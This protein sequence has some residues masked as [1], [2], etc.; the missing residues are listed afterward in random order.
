MKHTVSDEAV[1]LLHG[2]ARSHRSLFKLEKS[3]NRHGYQTC[4]MNYASTRF[5]IEQLADTVIKAALAQVKS[6][7][8]IHFVTHSMGGIMIRYYLKHYSIPEL[9][10]V[11]MLAPPNQGSQLA[12]KLKHL[13]LFQWI[14]GPAGMQLGTSELDIA[15][16][17]GELNFDAGIIAGCSNYNPFYA[18][19]LPGISDGKVTVENTRAGNM[20]DHL[21]LPLSHSFMMNNPVLIQQTICF[22]QHGRFQH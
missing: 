9:G 12:D 11:V 10:R 17:L 22:L 16:S 1:I 21:C 8:K 19:L 14:N 3:L 13:N 5:S 7:K 15:F 20:Q 18:L 2:L 6:A 4:N